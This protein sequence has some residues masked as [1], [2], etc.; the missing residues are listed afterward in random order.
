MPLRCRRFRFCVGPLCFAA[1]NRRHLSHPP[2]R[3]SPQ[4]SSE[5][6]ALVNRLTTFGLSTAHISVGRRLFPHSRLHFAA[7][8]HPITHLSQ[9]PTSGWSIHWQRTTS[10]TLLAT[11]P[12]H[13]PAATVT[14]S[15]LRSPD[16]P[17]THGPPHTPCTSPVRPYTSQL[18]HQTPSRR[19]FSACERRTVPACSQAHTFHGMSARKDMKSRAVRNGERRKHDTLTTSK[20]YQIGDWNTATRMHPPNDTAFEVVCREE[21]SSAD[22]LQ[23]S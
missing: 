17:D 21:W 14:F 2:P 22:R 12:L 5:P 19:P 23:T 13:L 4:H 9:F 10:F 3:P 1:S 6:L 11:S 15:K 18:T 16:T 8:R 7:P 20:R